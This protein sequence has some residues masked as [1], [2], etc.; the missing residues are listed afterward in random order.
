VS[1][2]SPQAT[3]ICIPLNG[4]INPS[5]NAR[6]RFGRLVFTLIPETET[7]RER[8]PSLTQEWSLWAKG[9][10]KSKLPI[11]TIPVPAPFGYNKRT[12][13]FA[14][15]DDH[16][17]LCWRSHWSLFRRL[18]RHTNSV[19]R[20]WMTRARSIAGAFVGSIRYGMEN[21]RLCLWY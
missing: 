16:I 8:E 7:E 11:V 4:S 13:W 12:L 3:K 18:L 21:E 19:C 14:L 15:R 1:S 10:Y 2:F 20:A 17:D 9:T 5:G 6:E